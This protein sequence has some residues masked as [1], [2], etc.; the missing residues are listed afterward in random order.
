LISCKETSLFKAL[1]KLKTPSLFSCS[2]LLQQFR[3]S[4]WRLG[5]PFKFQVQLFQTSYFLEI[6][7]ELDDSCIRNSVPNQNFSLF[8]M[9]YPGRSKYRSFKELSFGKLSQKICSPSPVIFSYLSEVQEPFEKNWLLW[10]NNMEFPQASQFDQTL[11][12][13]DD[14]FI[15]KITAI[16]INEGPLRLLLLNVNY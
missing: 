2:S 1:L 7:T 6:L 5:K 8:R 11:L 10:E 15:I 14:S 9:I 4:L 3:I 13:T 12:Q 16:M